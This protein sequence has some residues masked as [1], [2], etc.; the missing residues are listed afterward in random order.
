MGSNKIKIPIGDKFLVAMVNEWQDGMPVELCVY[1]ETN[2]GVVWQ[3]I[4]L[5]REHYHLL[6]MDFVRDPSL[7]DCKVW[8]N[9]DSE[10]YTDEFV[11][12]IWEEEND[13]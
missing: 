2:D 9:S 3:D 4:C 5:V 7:V 12:G 1:L 10:D 6:N 11:I 13:E 8:G